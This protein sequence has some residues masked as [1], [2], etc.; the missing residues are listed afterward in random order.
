MRE[1]E[2]G[3]AL[4]CKRMNWV[5]S[6]LTG[7]KNFLCSVR[8]GFVAFESYFVRELFLAKLA[9]ELRLWM[10]LPLMRLQIRKEKKL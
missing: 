8:R 3:N 10:L 4:L 2:D 9:F 1:T 6:K 5:T 7:T